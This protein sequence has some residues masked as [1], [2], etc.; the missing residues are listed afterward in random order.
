MNSKEYQRVHE[1]LVCDSPVNIIFQRDNALPPRFYVHILFLKNKEI[2]LLEWP[3]CSPDLNIIENV[4]IKLSSKVYING[5]K[6]EN[7][8]ELWESIQEWIKYIFRIYIHLSRSNAQ[9]N[10][11]PYIKRWRQL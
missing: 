3:S 9:N 1:S 2:Q 5:R 7:F 4:L 6:Y 8:E 10:F 11:K